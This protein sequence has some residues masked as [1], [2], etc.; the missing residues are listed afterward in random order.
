M[1]TEEELKKK[2]WKVVESDNTRCIGCDLISRKDCL[3]LTGYI[4]KSGSHFIV[5]EVK[6]E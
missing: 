6:D 1:V 3:K 5:K 2:K 4:C